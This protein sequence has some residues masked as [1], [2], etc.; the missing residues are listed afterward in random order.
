MFN[1]KLI[2]SLRIESREGFIKSLK[3]D[4]INSLASEL[5]KNF[6][7]FPPYEFDEKY[8]ISYAEAFRKFL[9]AKNERR[10][11]YEYIRLYD[12]AAN[13]SQIN[14]LYGNIALSL[15]LLYTILDAFLGSPKY[16]SKKLTCENCGNKNISH[17]VESLASYH[18][19]KIDELLKSQERS[20]KENYLKLLK[21]MNE[22]RSKTYHGAIFYSIFDG[23]LKEARTKRNLGPKAEAWT[24]ERI[25]KK[26]I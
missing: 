6:E 11:I 13:L 9:Q 4:P 23:W 24:L 5:K 7:H 19:R 26:R 10:K 15:S 22:I 17:Q 14:P 16:C 25:K 2:H 21:I 20:L 18:R 8:K 1:G 12:F 3:K